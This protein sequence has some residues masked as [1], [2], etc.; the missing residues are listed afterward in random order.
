M[1]NRVTSKLGRRQSHPSGVGDGQTKWPFSRRL[2]NRQTPCPS[3][4]SSLIS[5]PRLAT[6][7][8]QGA[9]ERIFRQ[10]LLGQHRQSVHPLA[11]IGV[12]ACQP[13]MRAGWQDDH[14]RS[15]AST[16]RKARGSI[17]ASTRTVVPSDKA[18]SIR[19]G[20]RAGTAT[21]ATG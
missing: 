15:A 3:N 4:Q 1:R 5:P 7:G 13:H 20:G 11:H 17:P 2:L 8:K 21:G 16:R 9:A 14:P 6:K 19:L 10:H 12:A 18:I